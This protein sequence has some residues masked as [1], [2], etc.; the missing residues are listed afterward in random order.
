LASDPG[1]ETALDRRGP[2]MEIRPASANLIAVVRHA[3]MCKAVTNQAINV[4]PGAALDA[5][6]VRRKSETLVGGKNSALAAQWH[7]AVYRQ[8][9]RCP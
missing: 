9:F 3:S 8:A 5:D 1:F 6:G 2:T 7:V 4:P